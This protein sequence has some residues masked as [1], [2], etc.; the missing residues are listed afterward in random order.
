MPD[1]VLPAPQM[2]EDELVEQETAGLQLEEP[3][4]INTGFNPESIFFHSSHPVL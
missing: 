1:L 2:E 4:P 3:L